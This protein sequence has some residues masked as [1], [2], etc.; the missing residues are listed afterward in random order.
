[1]ELDVQLQQNL[2]PQ[3]G[4]SQ[5]IMG[6]IFKKILKLKNLGIIFD[7]EKK[8]GDFNQPATQFNFYNKEAVSRRYILERKGKFLDVGARDGDLSYLLGIGSNLEKNSVLYRKNKKLFDEKFEYYG[9]DLNPTSKD[10]V[11]VGDICSD[12]FGEKYKDFFDV[13]YS[14]NVFEHLKKPWVAAD[15]IMRMTKKGGIVVTIVPFSQRYHQS[16]EDYFRYTH[17][18]INSLFEN[19]GNVEILESGYDILGRRNNWQGNGK[20]KDIVPVDKFGAWRETWITVSI[21][22]KV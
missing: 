14:N 18:G 6:N 20:K 17:V 21:I 4:H 7:F 1:M 2:S 10:R 9:I 16:P 3:F 8:L 5:K 22:K 12:G 11:L 19:C 15:N 13:V